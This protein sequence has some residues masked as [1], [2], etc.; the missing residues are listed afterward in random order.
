MTF[1]VLVC[2][3]LNIYHPC[4]LGIEVISFSNVYLSRH[5]SSVTLKFLFG[6]SFCWNPCMCAQRSMLGD[7]NCAMFQYSNSL[8]QMP[9][10]RTLSSES[11]HRDSIIQCNT[12]QVFRWMWQLIYA[13]CW[14][15]L[16]GGV[17]DMK[18]N[19]HILITHI[20]L[21]SISIW[22]M[23]PIPPHHRKTKAEW[24]RMMGIS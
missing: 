16:E 21:D 22:Y 23:G 11:Q 18:Q 20:W 1:Y 7:I 13:S 8:K 24:H 4:A 3:N 17:I 14:R 19:S 2:Q 12:Q 10:K 9:I 15:D 6:R 5:P